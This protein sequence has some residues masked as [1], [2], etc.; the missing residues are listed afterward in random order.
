MIKL[1]PDALIEYNHLRE[2]PT[3]AKLI[4]LRYTAIP[5]GLEAVA[6]SLRDSIVP[7]DRLHTVYAFGMLDENGT[8]VAHPN[9]DV[10]QVLIDLAQYEEYEGSDAEYRKRTAA[11]ARHLFSADVVPTPG[12]PH[13]AT[14]AKGKP[15]GEF[16]FTD[17]DA[18]VAHFDERLAGEVV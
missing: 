14:S 15:A 7:E 5:P 9:V 2:L 4:H 3:H 10:V 11:A 17:V 12:A 1:S 13:T 6:Q 18:I 16:R 8:F